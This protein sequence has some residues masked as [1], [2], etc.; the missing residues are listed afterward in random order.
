MDRIS[1]AALINRQLDLLTEVLSQG[2][3][4]QQH[5]GI[6]QAQYELRIRLLERLKVIVRSGPAA[7]SDHD[8]DS[9]EGCCGSGASSDT[10]P[11]DEQHGEEPNVAELS[12]AELT[13]RRPSRNDRTDNSDHDEQEIIDCKTTQDDG[14]RPPR[15]Q[16]NFRLRLEEPE[17]ISQPPFVTQSVRRTGAPLF[18][19]D[20]PFAASNAHTPINSKPM[21]GASD[22]QAPLSQIINPKDLDGSD[23][24]GSEQD[25]ADLGEIDGDDNERN[26]YDPDE[27]PPYVDYP[28]E[29]DLLRIGLDLIGPVEY[30]L[31]DDEDDADETSPEEA[32]SAQGGIWAFGLDDIDFMETES[33]VSDL[34][35]SYVDASEQ[36]EVDVGNNDLDG[37]QDDFA[38]LDVEDETDNQ[39]ETAPSGIIAESDSEDD[40]WR[41]P[42]CFDNLKKAEHIELECGHV[43]CKPCT[44]TF[45]DHAIN[46]ESQFPPKCCDL[47][48]PFDTAEL[49]LDLSMIRA[50][51]ENELE[52]YTIDRVYCAESSCSAFINPDFVDRANL[53]LCGKCGTITCKPCRAV[54]HEGECEI[55]PQ[56]EEVL[57]LGRDEGWQRCFRCRHLIAISHGC[58]HMQCS[59]GAEFCYVCAAPWKRCECPMMFGEE[60][61]DEA[62]I[63]ENADEDEVVEWEAARHDDDDDDPHLGT[64]WWTDTEGADANDPRPEPQ[65]EAEPVVRVPRVFTEEQQ[66]CTHS[67]RQGWP[68]SICHR[69]QWQ[70][71]YFIM[72]CQHCAVTVCRDC[73]ERLQYDNTNWR[74]PNL[75][76]PSLSG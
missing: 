31:D 29:G 57:K 2:I 56:T 69:C 6:R 4:A 17:M 5:S 55:D 42:F 7:S 41:C 35:E 33:E 59:C 46:N 73:S 45:F 40:S 15:W 14:P 25:E 32:Y 74:N 51:H 10:G 44:T 12:S 30:S 19:P 52:Y 28:D 9:T 27:D 61:G 8:S 50:Y 71:D 22:L 3:P 13:L 68:A 39:P 26:D 24:D 38:E 21:I 1:E 43:L 64:D 58:N 60:D 72:A 75:P 16:A 63:D 67:F 53:A 62:F 54:K 34:A 23:S 48:I 70:A 36:L 66:V 37:L 76:G 11:R 47:V 49:F 65:L 20:G 18:G